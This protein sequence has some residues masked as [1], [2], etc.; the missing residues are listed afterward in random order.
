[1]ALV[2]LAGCQLVAGT[3]TRVVDP[4]PEGCILPAGGNAKIRIANIKPDAQAVDFCVRSTGAT[5]YGR[6]LLRGGGTA[7]APSS[8]A[9]GYVYK[10]VSVPFTVTAGPVDIKTIPAGLTCAAPALS[11]TTANV[12]TDA[13]V[14]I[15]RTGGGDAPEQLIAMA[16]EPTLEGTSLRMR[17]FNGIVGSKPL[18]LGITK[19]GTL[20][21][22]VTAR[23][24]KNA[25]PY[26]TTPKTG[27]PG[28]TG[29]IDERGYF[30]MGANPIA[31]GAAEEGATKAVLVFFTT[32]HAATYTLYAIG[33]PAD[34]AFP[35]RGL[36]CDESATPSGLTQ[37]CVETALPTLSIDSFNVGLYGSNAPN[38]AARRPHIYNA[39]AQRD[40]DLQCLVEVG[41]KLDRD[42]ITNAAK[43]AG[44]FPYAYTPTTDLSTPPTDPRDQKGNAPAA[45]QYPACGG[46]NDAQRVA[47]A[48]ACL[49]E[50]CSTSAT[51]GDENGHLSGGTSCMS[52]RC[53]VSLAPLVTGTKDEKGCFA[54]IAD[55]VTGDVTFGQSKQACTTDARQPFAFDGQTPSMILSRYPLTNVDTLVLPSTNFRRAVLYAQVQLQQGSSVDFFCAQLSSPLLDQD[56]PYTGNYDNGDPAHG[57][58]QEQLLQTAQLL[59]WVKTK[60]SPKRPAILAGDWH[61]SLAGTNLTAVNAAVIEQLTGSFQP[62]QADGWQPQCTY[63][64]QA[65]NAYNGA[66]TQYLFATTFLWN[67]PAK[68]TIESSIIFNQPVVPGVGPN[69]ESGMLSPSFGYHARVIRP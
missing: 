66:D 11:E 34:N 50:K 40:A 22:E 3:E 48:Y 45:P 16:E 62:A 8:G 47:T 55:T 29:P 43:Q 12:G 1:V 25:V 4:I 60:K 54:C 17:F 35:T 13:V 21:T 51:P 33:T 20:P 49:E 26:G 39:V 2:A 44:T 37:P 53:G 57:Y 32:D 42:G 52:K 65:V 59:D 7:C 64:S 67:W 28:P 18:Y 38:E 46:T 9:A 30:S 56:L 61:A 5:D 24:L 6:P 19:D 27:D 36:L 10:D 68:A 41:R 63:C 23:L 69:G 31:L 15:V 14:T 58:D